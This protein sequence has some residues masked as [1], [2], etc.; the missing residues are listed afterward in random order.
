MFGK[1]FKIFDP[2]S[3]GFIKIDELINV[4]TGLGDTMTPQEVK[5]IISEVEKID[6]DKIKFDAFVKLMCS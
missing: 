3:K 1:L 4:L 6:N 2:E 5:D